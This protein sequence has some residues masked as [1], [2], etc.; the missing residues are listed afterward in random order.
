MK[1]TASINES[2]VKMNF[3]VLVVVYTNCWNFVTVLSLREFQNHC[4]F[5]LERWY[6]ALSPR[7]HSESAEK[8]DCFIVNVLLLIKRI[9]FTQNRINVH[10]K[11]WNH[12]RIKSGMKYV[13]DDRVWNYFSCVLRH[14][15]IL[16]FLQSITVFPLHVAFLY[17]CRVAP[18]CGQWLTLYLCMSSWSLHVG[19]ELLLAVN[20]QTAIPKMVLSFWELCLWLFWLK[21]QLRWL[22]DFSLSLERQNSPNLI[23]TKVIHSRQLNQPDEKRNDDNI[24]LI[25]TQFCNKIQAHIMYWGLSCFCYIYQQLLV[26]K[27]LCSVFSPVSSINRAHCLHACTDVW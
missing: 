25:S 15:W 26:S 11:F 24:L 8:L 23:C 1:Y 6:C 21:I 5:M 16:H 12:L 13:T 14:R 19:A 3:L 22:K 9:A 18:P 4:N 10:H 20:P 2:N 7:K 27:H 17:L